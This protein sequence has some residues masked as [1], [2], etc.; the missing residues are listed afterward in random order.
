MTRKHYEEVAAM[1][2][3]ERELAGRSK[4]AHDAVTRIT[5][6]LV[7]IFQQDNRAFKQQKFCDAAI[8]AAG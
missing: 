7:T 5:R 3:R 8:P 6:D 1:L 4:K 2:C